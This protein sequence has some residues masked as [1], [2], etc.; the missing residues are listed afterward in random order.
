MTCIQIDYQTCVINT[1]NKNIG[2]QYNCSILFLGKNDAQDFCSN[3]ITLMVIK[4]LKNA[5]L[6]KEYMGCKD[7][8]LCNN[9]IYNVLNPPSPKSYNYK[10]SVSFQTISFQNFIVESIEDSYDYSFIRVFSEIGGSIGILV[11]MSCMTIVEF[12]IEIYMKLSNYTT[13]RC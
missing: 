11:G 3:N 13:V 8:P 12:M 7:Y 6:Q 1:I 9:V 4:K 2:E 5:I 10:N